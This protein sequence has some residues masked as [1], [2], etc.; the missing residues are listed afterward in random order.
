MLATHFILERQRETQIKPIYLHQIWN[1]D[2]YFAITELKPSVDEEE[3]AFKYVKSEVRRKWW[4]Y[5]SYTSLRKFKSKQDYSITMC[6]WIQTKYRLNKD[7][8][9]FSCIN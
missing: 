3:V 5:T 9:V 6:E 4:C 7:D 8:Q 2:I 1:T